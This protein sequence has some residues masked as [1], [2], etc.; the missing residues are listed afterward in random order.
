MSPRIL[1]KCKDDHRDATTGAKGVDSDTKPDCI[2]G[3]SSKLNDDGPV[4][5][6]V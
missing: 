2:L 4:F 1:T 3:Y 5:T 6:S